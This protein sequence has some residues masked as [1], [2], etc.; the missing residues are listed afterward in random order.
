MTD[1]IWVLDSSALVNF[2]DDIPVQRQWQ[3][4]K[5]LEEM[6]TGGEIALPRKVIKEVSEIA[7]PDLP[8][9]WAP[10]MRGLLKH[11]VDAD[12]RVLRYVMERA[13]NVVDPDDPRDD[14]DP[15]VL[16]LA[17]QLQAPGRKAIVV[18]NDEKDRLPNKIALTTACGILGVRSVSGRA[19]LAEVGIPLTS[20]KREE[21]TQAG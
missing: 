8:G 10:G 20:P 4:F 11:P 5:R 3:A 18:T 15:H 13:K 9:A 1:R 17:L 14:A 19:F 16:A 12:D 6:V 2:K 21:D 7:H